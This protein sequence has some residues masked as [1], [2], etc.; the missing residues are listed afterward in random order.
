M[1]GPVH[2]P[3]PMNNC[4]HEKL[5]ILLH[6]T[7]KDCNIRDLDLLLLEIKYIISLISNFFFKYKAP[8]CGFEA[9]STL[10]V[11]L[12]IT[13][14]EF[15]FS[16][17]NTFLPKTVHKLLLSNEFLCFFFSTSKDQTSFFKVK[18]STIRQKDN[19]KNWFVS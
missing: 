16:K 10:L 11:V 2:E 4:C 13:L 3:T 9:V 12:L 8:D 14:S 17:C 7:G 19:A 15:F 5:E 6:P 18:Y 1:I